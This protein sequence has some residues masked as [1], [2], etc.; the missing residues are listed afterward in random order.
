MKYRFDPELAD[1]AASIPNEVV[2]DPV[3]GRAGLEIMTAAMAPHIDLTGLSVEEKMIPGP[4]HAPAVKVR[5]YKPEQIA[6]TAGLL[7][8]HGGGF[9]VGSLDTEHFSAAMIARE[10]KAVVVS[11][12]YRLAPENPYPAGLEDCYAALTW[13]YE[14]A[15]ALGVDRAR[16]GVSG[17]SAGGGLSAALTLLAL[18][19]N[20]PKL[21]FQLLGMPELDD[22]LQTTSMREF[23]DTPLWNRPSAALSWKHYLG[24]DYQPGGA[25]VPI[26]AAPARAAVDELRNLPPAYITAMEFDPLRDEDVLYAL[27]L[28]EAG[29]PVELHTFPGTFHGSALAMTATVS[30]R[31]G[32]EMLDALQRGRRGLKLDGA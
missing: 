8:I 6:Q 9:T 20:G 5:I 27:R 7:Y 16:I 14:Q 24:A 30:Q 10:L 2:D 12:D 28:M 26:Y 29:V 18:D 23:I 4:T 31:Q 17:Q 15:A 1:F 19:R 3:A 21:C 13:F 11:V 22:R 25:D 32:R